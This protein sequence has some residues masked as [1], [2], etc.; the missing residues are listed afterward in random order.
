VRAILSADQFNVSQRRQ[1]GYVSINDYYTRARRRADEKKSPW[2]LLQV[3]LTIGGTW[4][5]YRIL[6]LLLFFGIV[7]LR[8]AHENPESYSSANTRDFIFIGVCTASY[9]FGMMISNLIFWAIRPLRKIQEKETS[10]KSGTNFKHA[11]LGLF[12]AALIFMPLGLGTAT[13]V[14]MYGH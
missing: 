5:V 3:P 10:A 1:K 14:A 8:P 2:N 9:P 12:K 6:I 11:M 4:L 13:L 7:H